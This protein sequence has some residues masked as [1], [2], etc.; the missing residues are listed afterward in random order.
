[1]PDGYVNAAY[2]QVLQAADGLA[3]YS[4]AIASGALPAGLLLD[5][6]SGTVA[7]TPTSTGVSTVSFEVTDAANAT[8]TKI[9]S[10]GVYELP[11][12]GTA[13]L[14]LGNVSLYAMQDLCPDVQGQLEE[15]GR[16]N[17]VRFTVRSMR[18]GV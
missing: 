8:A 1:M 7:G 15:L 12:I 14:A 2:S 17:D 11:K 18:A 16:Q 4:W 5:G 9:F 10:F 6:Q 13:S 3:P